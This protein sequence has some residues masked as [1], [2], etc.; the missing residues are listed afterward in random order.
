MRAMYDDASFPFLSILS[1]YFA[2]DVLFFEAQTKIVNTDS[3]IL[4]LRIVLM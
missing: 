1:I 2:M 3:V 4:V